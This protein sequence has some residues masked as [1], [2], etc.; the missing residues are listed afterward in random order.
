M[1]TCKITVAAL[2]ICAVAASCTGISN[3][4]DKS[5]IE[6]LQTEL[7][8]VK[9]D[10][11]SLQNQYRQ[12]NEE[13][14]R[15]IEELAAVSGKTATLRM[16]VESGSARMTQAETISASIDAIK[17][18]I[19]ALE[20]ENSVF[21]GKNKEFKKMVDGFHKVI[22][23][24][25][26]QIASLKRDIENKEMTIRSQ[27]ET[28]A[29]QSKTIDDQMATIIDQSEELKRTVAEQAKM[30]CDAGIMMEE[31]ADNAPEVS[32]KKNKEKIASMAQDIYAKALSYYQESYESGYKP[33]LERIEAVK[34]K[35]R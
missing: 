2:V 18:H 4:T 9:A 21:S 19:A 35:I 7:S 33:A 25:E 11:S 5:L 30:L 27:K 23:E 22:E 29:S 34:A 20:K 31:I 1:R 26:Q 16:D 12:Q 14:S 3:S 8:E 6:E 15:I 13:L 17:A 32:W 24:Q 10:R 28:I